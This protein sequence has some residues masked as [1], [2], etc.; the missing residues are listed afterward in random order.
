MGFTRWDRISSSIWLDLTGHVR[1][2]LFE[3][4]VS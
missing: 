2:D 4:P 3:R 1:A